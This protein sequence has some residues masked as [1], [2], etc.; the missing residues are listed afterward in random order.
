SRATA[1]RARPRRPVPPSPRRVRPAAT[2]AAGAPD[3]GATATT[4]PAA[5][6]R[7]PG[8]RARADYDAGPD[9]PYAALGSTWREAAAG[10]NAAPARRGQ[11]PTPSSPDVHRRHLPT[12]RRHG[13]PHRTGP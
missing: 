4:R 10:D 7:S 2:R 5:A 6:G 13:A 3:A 1:V 12:P 11:T 8:H 9:R